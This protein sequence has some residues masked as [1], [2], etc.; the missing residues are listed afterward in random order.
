MREALSLCVQKGAIE[1]VFKWCC[2]DW[3]KF[4]VYFCSCKIELWQI[5]V[6][7]TLVCLSYDRVHDFP[8]L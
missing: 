6:S 3:T 7:L 2:Y 1:K 8:Y 4:V 5:Y